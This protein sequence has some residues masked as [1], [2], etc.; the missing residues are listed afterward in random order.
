MTEDNQTGRYGTYG[1][2]FIPETLMSEIERITAAYNHYKADPEFLKEFHDLLNNYA[3]RPS[4]LY[5]AEQMTADHGG[6]Q[7]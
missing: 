5:F 1:G 7:I 4:L 6:A 3:N 2:Q